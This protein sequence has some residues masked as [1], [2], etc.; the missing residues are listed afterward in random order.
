MPLANMF[1]D[2]W[3]QWIQPH[4][5]KLVDF[6]NK[7]ERCLVDG[8]W[9]ILPALLDSRQAYLEHMFNQ[10]IPGNCQEALKR[11][12]QSVL[13][14]DVVFLSRVEVQKNI[15]AQQQLS[16]NRGRRA[17]QAYNNS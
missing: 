15:I 11:L 9:E 8:T 7:I 12:A 4:E 6:R 5:E 14:D 3:C 1:T 16:F 2:A 13:D 10:P 17:M